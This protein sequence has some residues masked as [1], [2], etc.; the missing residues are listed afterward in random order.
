MEWVKIPHGEKAKGTTFVAV[1]DTGLLMRK[2]GDVV[3]STYRQKIRLNG[4]QRVYQFIADN[5]LV[6]VRRPDQTHIDHGTHNPVGM[7]INDVR[8]LRWCTAAENNRFD[9]HRSNLSNAKKGHVAWNK[10]IKMES[11]SPLK[12]RKRGSSWN[13]GLSGEDYTKHFKN[14]VKNQYTKGA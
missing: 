13:K 10:G 1:S 9:E 14:G 12:G 11:P 6:T 5:F 3:E 2:N 4:F 8:N 7:N